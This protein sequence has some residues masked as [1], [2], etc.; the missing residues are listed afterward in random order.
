MIC[1]SLQT[2]AVAT[3]TVG[4]N[5]VSF[6]QNCAGQQ[7]TATQVENPHQAERTTGL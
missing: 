5:T 3:W 1:G 2:F 4:E 6:G 7:A